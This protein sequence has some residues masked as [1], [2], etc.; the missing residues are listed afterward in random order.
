MQFFAGAGK[1]TSG[2]DLY[3]QQY[4]T[5]AEGGLP[6]LGGLLDTDA[7]SILWQQDQP[8]FYDTEY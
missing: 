2:F 5:S 8:E 3:E 7:E 6:R 4:K 1:K